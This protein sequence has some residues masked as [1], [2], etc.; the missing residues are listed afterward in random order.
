MES[1]LPLA[2][3]GGKHETANGNECREP[4]PEP[5]CRGTGDPRG[6]AEEGPWT[7]VEDGKGTVSGKSLTKSHERKRSEDKENRPL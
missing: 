5:G 7:R 3:K 4:P 6:Q 1:G 2:G